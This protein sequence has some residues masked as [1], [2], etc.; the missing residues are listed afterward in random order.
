MSGA[1]VRIVPALP[2]H[3]AA[4][5]EVE[6]EAEKQF[7]PADLPPQL[8]GATLTDDAEFEEARR[9]GLLW[10]A[11]D[12]AGRPIGY[13]IALWMDGALHLDELDVL[14]AHQR[15]GVGRALVQA[16]C[17]RA[18]AQG[19]RRVTLTTFRFVP[20]NRPWYERLGFV[21]LEEAALPA[22]LRELFE[23]EIARGLARERRVAMALELAT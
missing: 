7:P 6:R 5:R 20:W 22:E 9:E 23:E 13:A 12:A 10:A 18:R 3:Y 14:P 17:D 1:D 4:L 8:L 11:L 16:V 19:A 2:A 21:A 15:R